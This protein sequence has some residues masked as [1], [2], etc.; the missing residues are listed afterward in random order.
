[1]VIENRATVLSFVQRTPVVLPRF[2]QH[3]SAPGNIPML[4]TQASATYTDEVCEMSWL[5]AEMAVDVPAGSD[6]DMGLSSVFHKSQQKPDITY[7][8]VA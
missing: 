2:P 6:G 7:T 5:D 4:L 1:M 8:S 3:L